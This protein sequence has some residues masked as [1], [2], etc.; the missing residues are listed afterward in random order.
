VVVVE[1]G[2]VT[3]C[4]PYEAVVPRLRGGWGAQG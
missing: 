1:D 2:R 3:A 4:G